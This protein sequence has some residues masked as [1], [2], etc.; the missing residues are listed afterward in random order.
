[1]LCGQDTHR[2]D[3]QSAAPRDRDRSLEYRHHQRHSPPEQ[4]RPQQYARGSDSDLE[5]YS[6]IWEPALN[7]YMLWTQGRKQYFERYF[8]DQVVVCALIL[9]ICNCIDSL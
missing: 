2:F 4:Q 5:D 6:E 1:V 7:E 9:C 8:Q 3:G